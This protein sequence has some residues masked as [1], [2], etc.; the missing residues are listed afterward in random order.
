M[1]SD[2]A[3]A[4][5]D[6]VRL[7]DVGVRRGGRVVVDGVNLR[8]QHGQ[9]YLLRGPN[10]AGK[11]SLLRLLG[12]F[13]SPEGG[14]VVREPELTSVFLGHADGVKAALTARD[15]LKFWQALYGADDPA[16][17]AAGAALSI[18][19][20]INSRAATLSAGQ[21]RRLAL[22]RVLIS[23]CGF[24]ILDEPTAGM[25]SG[26]IGAVVDLIQ[27]H[28][29]RG[30]LAIVATHEPLAIQNAHTITLDTGGAA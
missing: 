6:A 20:F 19:A 23:G 8:L 12:G 29:A 4:A 14:V 15:N 25:D 2:A 22:C 3:G 10:G 9:C 11:T 17:A 26:S 18:D 7:A 16:V 13:S 5:P 24:W 1:T 30:G 21:R 28:C 27:S